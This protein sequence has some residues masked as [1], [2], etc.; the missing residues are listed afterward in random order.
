MRLLR[1]VNR[2]TPPFIW[3][4]AKRVI[5]SA[6][7]VALAPFTGDAIGSFSQY[8]EDL[9]V[10]AILGSPAEGVYVDVGANDPELLSNTMRFYRRGWRGISVEPNTELWTALGRMRPEDINLNLG[11][12]SESGEM[13]FYRMDPPTLSTFDEG[14]SRDNLEHPG[15]R[16][17]EELPVR[18]E[19]L[20][21]ILGE[22]LGN[23]IID[24]LSVDTEG[25][26]LQVLGSNDWSVYRPRLVLVEVAWRGAE[27]VAFMQA[28][29]YE[30]VWCNGPNGIFADSRWL[31]SSDAR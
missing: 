3:D 2:I 25:L 30:F 9:V 13:T 19:P 1:L 12:A 16:V 15:S 14:A 20:A 31:L 7:D 26:D 6:D 11:I 21:K 10:D 29:E 5:V 23:R 22:H 27:V 17:V 8:G 4:L 24:L 18:V 28:Q